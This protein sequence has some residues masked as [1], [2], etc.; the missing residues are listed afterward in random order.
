VSSLDRRACPGAVRWRSPDQRRLCSRALEYGSRTLSSLIQGKGEDHG[1]NV[2]AYSEIHFVTMSGGIFEHLARASTRK[3][4]STWI[5]HGVELHLAACMC[6]APCCFPFR[7]HA[8]TCRF[9]DHVRSMLFTAIDQTRPQ[10]P[11]RFFC[12]SSIGVVS[13]APASD[14]SPVPTSG[15]N[16]L[17]FRMREISSI[18]LSLYAYMPKFILVFVATVSVNVTT[19]FDDQFIQSSLVSDKT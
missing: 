9:D 1:M 17:R 2:W 12:C 18:L 7:E 8:E 14:S 13:C 15:L 3:R 6:P 5:E 4:G 10:A 16:E 11:N 19:E